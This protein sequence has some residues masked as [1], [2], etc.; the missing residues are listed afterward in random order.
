MAEGLRLESRIVEHRNEQI[1]QRCVF[2]LLPGNVAAVFEPA[3]GQEDRQIACMVGV[4]VAGHTL[5]L[6]DHEVVLDH[7]ADDPA[8]IGLHDQ[9]DKIHRIRGRFMSRNM[10]TRDTANLSSWHL[11]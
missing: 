4:G 9:R 11:R 5:D 8:G 7:D 6:G 3:A 10:R 2:L 1:A